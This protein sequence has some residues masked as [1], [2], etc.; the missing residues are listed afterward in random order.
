MSKKANLLFKK[1]LWVVYRIYSIHPFMLFSGS[2]CHF[3]SG[4]QTNFC[5]PNFPEAHVKSW[6]GTKNK[7]RAVGTVWRQGATPPP[8]ILTDTLTLS[9]RGGGAYHAYHITT[10]SSPDFQIYLHPWRGGT[11]VQRKSNAHEKFNW[12]LPPNFQN[13]GQILKCTKPPA[14]R[15]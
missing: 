11:G 15:C 7:K 10:R 6:H 12:K 3:Y 14:G 1:N 9:N 2:I 8:Q 13:G 5:F 4:I